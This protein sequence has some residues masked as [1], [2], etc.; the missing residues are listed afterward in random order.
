MF[1]NLFSP[2]RLAAYMILLVSIN[3]SPLFAQKQYTLKGVITENASGKPLSGVSVAIT[4]GTETIVTN[5]NGE[6][7]V[8]LK[9]GFYRIRIA[10]VGFIT[11]E[12]SLEL[13]GPTVRNIILVEDLQQLLEVKVT[14]ATKAVNLKTPQMSLNRLSST[15]L[16]KIPAIF[17]EVDPLKAILQFPGVTNAGEGSSG[18]NVRGG[19]SDQNLILFDGAPLYSSSHLFGMFSIFNPDVVENLT[20]YKG[21]IPAIYGGRASSVLDINSKDLS[22]IVPEVSGG[23]GLITSRLA[24][25][26]PFNENKGAILVS[27]RSSYAHLFLKL[28][29]NENTAYF[30]DLNAKTDYRFGEN[31]RLS[32]SLYLGNDVLGISNNFINNYGN[33]F[34]NAVWKH[35]FSK[36]ADG[37]LT[38]VYSGYD[39]RLKINTVGLDWTAGINSAKIQYDLSQ[40]ISKSL[41]IGYGL[42]L[43]SYQIKPGEIVPFGDRSPVVPLKYIDKNSFE[44]SA[45]FQAMQMLTPMLSI[46]YGV[47]LSSFFRMGGRNLNLYHSGPVIYDGQ[48]GI[49]TAAQPSA[50]EFFR[51]SQVVDQYLFPEPRVALSFQLKEQQ[52]IKL[53]YHRMVQYLHLISNSNSPTPVDVWAPSDRYFKPQLADQVGI[54]YFRNLDKENYSLE[55]EAYFKKIQNRLDY[56]DGANLVGNDALEQVILNGKSR[57]YGL[58]L[59]FR[60]NYGKLTGWLSYTLSRTEQQTKGNNVKGPGINNGHWYLTNYDKPH[61]LSLTVLYAL[62]KKLSLGTTFTYQSGRPTSYPVGKF[63]YLGI[64]VPIYGERNA[65]RLPDF[66]HLDLSLSYIPNQNVKKRIKVEWVLSIYNLYNRKN[67]SSLN[68][69]QNRDTYQSESVRLSLFGIV[70]ALTYNFKFK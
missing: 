21:G 45:Y 39:F 17:G 60:K 59:L 19:A 50:S 40:V 4:G 22:A 43:I 16:Q 25:K 6:Y 55:I 7:L 27:A 24:A 67:T 68:F 10:C 38:A 66:H 69:S 23:L 52:S 35:H 58:E 18:F 41:K 62:S 32:L 53:S 5:N 31:D 42:N 9:Q 44:S 13:T 15:E 65:Y 70:P 34:I 48:L 20:L 61:N 28:S 57:A 63:N 11:Q 26:A 30:Y 64:S 29:G 12:I 51:S 3:T 14:G 2:L 36:N 47:R 8:N 56:I 54:G 33:A 1:S 46:D 37:K 49:Y